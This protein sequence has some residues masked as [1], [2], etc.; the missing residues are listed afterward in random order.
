[1]SQTLR[2]Q[3]IGYQ[4]TALVFRLTISQDL[5]DNNSKIKYPKTSKFNKKTL[6]SIAKLAKSPKKDVLEFEDLDDLEKVAVL[7]AERIYPNAYAPY[8]NSKSGSAVISISG[9]LYSGVN[10]ENT[11]Y[12]TYHSEINAL[13][14][15]VKAGERQFKVMACVAKNISI[16]C[17]ICRKIM[18]EFSGEN[19]KEVT[20]I[21]V[22][23]NENGS[24]RIIKYTFADVIGIGSFSLSNNPLDF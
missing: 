11:A 15:M 10:V 17:S 18:R 9:I 8:S 2:K 16:P 23:I 20:I 3:N 14:E 1:M 21:S 19:L 12:Q 7:E 6:E 5:V 4:K 13:C 22:G 24:R